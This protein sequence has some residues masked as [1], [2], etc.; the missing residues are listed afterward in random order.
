MN[1]APSRIGGVQGRMDYLTGKRC[2][3]DPGIVSTFQA[4]KDISPYLPKG[5][6]ALKYAD[7]QQLF[8]Q[9]QAAMFLGGSWDVGAFEAQKP[10]F[11]WSVFATPSLAGQ[12]GFV[13]FHLDAGIGINAASKNKD[14]AKTFLQWMMTP[15]FDQLLGNELPGFFPVGKNAVTLN[16][17]HA[18]AFLKLNEGRGQD[19]RFVWQTLADV[20]SGQEAPYNIIQDDSIAI[21]KGTLTPQQA[22]DD[23]QT[24][25]AKWFAPAQKCK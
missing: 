1:I 13:S 24:N 18:N 17:D 8:L 9:G 22:A 23:L 21:T 11:K 4:V 10:T 3:N 5:Q 14:A 7:S 19:I 12:P 2:F 6:E 16:N 25:L 15:E 20:P